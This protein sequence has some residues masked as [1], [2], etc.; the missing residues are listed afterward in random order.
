MMRRLVLVVGLTTAMAGG[1]ILPLALAAGAAPAAEV[2]DLSLSDIGLFAGFSFVIASVLSIVMS[3]WIDELALPAGVIT[4]QVLCVVSL[5]LPAFW[6][7]R[8]TLIVGLLLAGLAM[9]LANPV[10][11]RLIVGYVRPRWR[12]ILV[13]LKQAGI[14]AS[15]LLVGTVIVPVA[16][17]V[18]FA[19]ALLLGCAITLPAMMLLFVKPI[20]VQEDEPA[21]APSGERGHTGRLTAFSFFTGAATQAVIIYLASYAHRKADLDATLAGALV[22]IVGLAS[23]VGRPYWGHSTG[24]ATDVSWPMRIVVTGSVL[25]VGLIAAVQLTPDRLAFQTLIVACLLL[26]ITGAAANA[27]AMAVVVRRAAPSELGRA[28]AQVSGAMFAGFAVG[29]A[30]SAVIVGVSGFTAVW[31]GAA[32]M[33]LCAGLVVRRLR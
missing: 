7:S 1:P 2:F 6:P 19:K 16:T 25:A 24:R 32:A 28:S 3:R 11:N 18:D 20:G 26:G 13:G 31:A 29:P 22:A 12:G 21:P 10:T 8:G 5:C 33:Y 17:G 4:L 23:L 9:G 27:V 14:P 30:V 15:Q